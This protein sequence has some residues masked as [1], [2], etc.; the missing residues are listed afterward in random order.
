M[1]REA[2]A[3]AQAAAERL[4]TDDRSA[5]V[6]YYLIDRGRQILE[7][8]VGCRLPWRSRCVRASRQFRLFLYLGPILLLTLVATAVVLLPFGGFAPGDWR[9]WFF[10][11]TGIIG[12]SALAVPLVNLL[13]TLV[14]PPRALPRLD[15]SKGI[16][17]VHRTMV[18]VPTL[19]GTAAG[20]R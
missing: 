8:A 19:L 5:H 20:D 17:A 12:A 6:G 11:I 1:A 15:F 4:G 3:L 16:P 9:Y 7:R 10:A 18:V 2:I 14:L 13:V